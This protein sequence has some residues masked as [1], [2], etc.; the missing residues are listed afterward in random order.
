MVIEA[1]LAPSYITGMCHGF[2]TDIVI[3]HAC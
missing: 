2:K 3:S 1:D